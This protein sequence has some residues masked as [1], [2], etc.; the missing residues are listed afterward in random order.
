MKNK[1]LIILMF[2]IIFSI[3]STLSCQAV[4]SLD[5]N[6][7]S[8]VLERQTY[9]MDVS[10][11]NI[12]RL[13]GKYILIPAVFF[14]PDNELRRDSL[15]A[16][17]FTSLITTGLKCVIGRTRPDQYDQGY[18]LFAPFTDFNSSMPSGHTTTAFALMTV[19][20]NRYPDYKIH[21]YSLATLVAISR[22]YN[23]RHWL[24]DVIAGALIGHYGARFTLSSW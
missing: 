15:K 19:M 20:A 1:V 17:F 3:I 21:A 7:R 6:S 16:M 5:F 14:I 11:K 18:N 12:S 13:G 9:V 10:M 23:D 4:N 24:T 8:F 22:I 2:L